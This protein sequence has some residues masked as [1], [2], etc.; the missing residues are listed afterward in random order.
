MKLEPVA[1][2][3]LALSAPESRALVE[4]IAALQ[5]T[6]E[7]LAFRRRRDLGG[8][9]WSLGFSGCCLSTV[10][11]ALLE[12]LRSGVIFATGIELA[13]ARS[14]FALLWFSALLLGAHGRYR[15]VEK[16]LDVYVHACVPVHWFA[17]IFFAIF[18]LSDSSRRDY[19]RLCHVRHRHQ[20]R[21]RDLTVDPSW[22]RRPALRL[23]RTA[24]LHAHLIPAA[25]L[26]VLVGIRLGMDGRSRVHQR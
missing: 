18:G 8:A 19:C 20:H 11:E 13:S 12:F 2:P 5:S 16:A 7:L 6:Y 14:G 22:S 15:V 25:A 17:P 4:P 26:L 1:N 9:G 24:D 21:H 23:R 3:S 10:L